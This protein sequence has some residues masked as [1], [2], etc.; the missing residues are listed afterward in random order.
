MKSLNRSTLSETEVALLFDPSSSSTDDVWLT[1]WESY[2]RQHFSRSTLT[3]QELSERFA[4]S[5][6]TLLRYV[7]RLTGHT[8]NQYLQETRLSEARYLLEARIYRSVSKL[9]YEVGYNDVRSFSRAFKNR[10]GKLP[11]EC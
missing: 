7:K 6:S 4:M 9:A 5:P 8:P 11:S 10:Y 1:E 3:V 2:I